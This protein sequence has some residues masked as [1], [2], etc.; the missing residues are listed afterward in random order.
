MPKGPAA[1]AAES[2]CIQIIETNMKIDFRV[3]KI[4]HLDSNSKSIL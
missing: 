3:S 1:I 4:Y 2:N